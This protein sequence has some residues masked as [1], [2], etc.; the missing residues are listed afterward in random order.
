MKPMTK[1]VERCYR[2]LA[3]PLVPLFNVLGFSPNA[4]TSLGL[5]IGVGVGWLIYDGR[6]WPALAA[7]FLMMVLDHVD[8]QLARLTGKSSAF[9]GFFDAVTDRMRIPVIVLAISAWLF[10]G[11][12]DVAWLYLGF[13]TNAVMLINA[14]VGM[15]GMMTEPTDEA[16]QKV[17]D[18]RNLDSG[19]RRLASGVMNLDLADWLNNS[20]VL[21]VCL[22]LGRLDLYLWV[23]LVS[24]SY[25]IVMQIL[26]QYLLQ[27]MVRSS[28]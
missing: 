19:V 24:G 6:H 7:F 18:S 21:I 5:L 10:R 15:Q 27:R 23:T 20:L 13:C 8:G 9:G 25:S 3:A 1:Q 12:G 28:S 11:D 17:R 16:K 14:L 4:V 22:A 2:L 26:R